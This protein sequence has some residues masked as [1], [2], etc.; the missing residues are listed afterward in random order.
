MLTALLKDRAARLTEPVP[1]EAGFFACLCNS[2]KRS[3]GRPLLKYCCYPSALG[4]PIRKKILSEFE[5]FC[6][7]YGDSLEPLCSDNM[8]N[9]ALRRGLVSS[10]NTSEGTLLLR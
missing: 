4:E 9:V 10:N 6:S 1:M 8:I 3:P 5:V 7:D 2:G